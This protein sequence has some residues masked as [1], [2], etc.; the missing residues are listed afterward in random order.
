MAQLSPHYWTRDIEGVSTHYVE[1]LGFE[2]AER[3]PEEGAMMWC[4][5]HLGEAQ[6][7]FGELPDDAKGGLV[8][9][10]QGR[11]GGKEALSVYINCGDVD[12]HRAHAGE[13][14]AKILEDVHDTFYG[15]REYTVEDPDGHLLSFFQPIPQA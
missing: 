9:E 8:D 5:L 1:V 2:L 3:F 11:M 14:G 6:V 15:L 13:G 10:V 7:M 12:A 4:C